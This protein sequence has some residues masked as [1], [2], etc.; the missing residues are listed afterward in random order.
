MTMAAAMQSRTAESPARSKASRIAHVDIVTDLA[1][2]ETVWRALEESG[3]LF[4]PYQRFDLLS[5]WQR[6]VGSHEGAS[7]FIVIARDAGRQPLLL[8]PLALRQGHGVRTACFMGG[9]HTT[10]NMGLWNAELQPRSPSPIS[11]RCLRRC[12]SMPTCSR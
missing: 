2:A 7:P 12:A 6:L 9:K 11:T 8:L 5:P 1:E 10:F 3:Q 4:T